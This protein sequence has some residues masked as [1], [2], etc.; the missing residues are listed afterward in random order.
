MR[1]YL[2]SATVPESR[3]GGPAQPL[4]WVTEN[5]LTFAEDPRRKVLYAHAYI[6]EDHIYKILLKKDITQTDSIP[7]LK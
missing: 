6:A 3:F 2:I 5:I 1:V 7:M 4:S